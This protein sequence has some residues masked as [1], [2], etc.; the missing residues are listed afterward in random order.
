[1]L[2]VPLLQPPPGSRRADSRDRPGSVRSSHAGQN[3]GGKSAKNKKV[4]RH[5]SLTLKNVLF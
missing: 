1:M 3:K 2:F 5:A 4:R